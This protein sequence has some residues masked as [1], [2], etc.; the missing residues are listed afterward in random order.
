MTLV[1][2]SPAVT[3]GPGEKAHD[4]RFCSAGRRTG[5]EWGFALMCGCLG[6]LAVAERR[7]FTA[8]VQDFEVPRIF[9]M[10]FG[11]GLC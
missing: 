5:R 9:A 2:C 3:P 8:F 4:D 6:I 10:R 1:V 7:C 11:G